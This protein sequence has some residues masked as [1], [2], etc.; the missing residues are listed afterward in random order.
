MGDMRL[1]SVSLS[2]LATALVSGLLFPSAKSTKPAKLSPEKLT[3]FAAAKNGLA[4]VTRPWHILVKFETFD[5]DGKHSNG[6]TFEE[7]WFGPASYKSVYTSDTLHQTDVA[8]PQGLFRTGDQRWATSEEHQVPQLLFSPLNGHF[9]P[10]VYWLNEENQ[11]YAGTGL[12]CILLT[13]PHSLS[14]QRTAPQTHDGM[15]FTLGPSFCLD[16]N[17]DALRTQSS[18]PSRISTVF[19][20]VREFGGQFVAQHVQSANQ[21]KLALDLRVVTLEELPD[22]ST[23]PAAD[24]GSQGPIQGP[25]DLPDGW[26]MMAKGEADFRDTFGHA[27]SLLPPN[28]T[29]KVALKVAIDQTGRVTDVELTEGP[30]DFGGVVAKAMKKVIFVPFQIA[31]APVSVNLTKSYTFNTQV[32]ISGAIIP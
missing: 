31:G 29:T 18:G 27:I 21:G 11:G 6:G 14:R 9:D 30:K 2:C 13:P 8:T 20:Q 28:S 1:G 32:S 3:E 22:S 26:M 23:P 19:N 15:D 5:K 17:T 16:P 12:H 7:W 10:E 4:G 24:P 25:I